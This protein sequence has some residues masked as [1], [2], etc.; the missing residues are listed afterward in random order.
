MRA[1]C[2]IYR[3]HGKIRFFCIYLKKNLFLNAICHKFWTNWRVPCP[4]KSFKIC[5]NAGCAIMSRHFLKIGIG[6]HKR[7]HINF[8]S[9]GYI[10]FCE[11]NHPYIRPQKFNSHRVKDTYI[12]I[13]MYSFIVCLP[14]EKGCNFTSTAWIEI[15]VISTFLCFLKFLFLCLRIVE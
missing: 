1:R 15:F 8:I 11:A 3:F 13:L 12:I 4:R 2:D 10:S 9:D 5:L 6:V 14:S 7:Y